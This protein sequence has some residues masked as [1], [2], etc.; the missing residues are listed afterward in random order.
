[1]KYLTQF[2]ACLCEHISS[3]PF[4]FDKN[5]IKAK[6][7]WQSIMSSSSSSSSKPNDHAYEKYKGCIHF[8]LR[9]LHEMCIWSEVLVLLITP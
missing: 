4:S 2:F 3:F 9:R 1:M 5:R 7:P 8:T 6:V